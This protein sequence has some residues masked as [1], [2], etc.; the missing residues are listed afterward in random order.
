MLEHI[1]QYW[2]EEIGKNLKRKL[3]LSYP[4]KLQN[5]AGCLL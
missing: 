4:I 5:I 2:K 1:K 3:F